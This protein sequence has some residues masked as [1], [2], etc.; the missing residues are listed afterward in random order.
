MSL[1][2]PST[3]LVQHAFERAGIHPDVGLNVDRVARRGD[4]VS[5]EVRLCYMVAHP[6]CCGEPACYIP[7]LRPDGLAAIAERIRAEELLDHAPVLPSRLPSCSSQGFGS[8]RQT[9]AVRT[10]LGSSTGI[11]NSLRSRAASWAFQRSLTSP[12]HWSD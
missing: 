3:A 2:A 7:A 8:S 6:I 1:S 9:W 12:T 4:T 11:L 5:V 10:A